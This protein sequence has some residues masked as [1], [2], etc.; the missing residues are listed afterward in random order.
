MGIAVCLHQIQVIY[1]KY[2]YLID[3]PLNH[4]ASKIK[5]DSPRSEVPCAPFVSANHSRYLTA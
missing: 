4:E 5:N 1:N 3:F 2:K